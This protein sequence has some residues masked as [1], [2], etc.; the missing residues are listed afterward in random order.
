MNPTG[1][2]RESLTSNPE[3]ENSLV[4]VLNW[5]YTFKKWFRIM[6]RGRHS[7]PLFSMAGT[8]QQRRGQ[9]LP[10]LQAPQQWPVG[11]TEPLRA[12]LDVSYLAPF[13]CRDRHP[14]LAVRDDAAHALWVGCQQRPSSTAS[15]RKQFQNRAV[16]GQADGYG[17]LRKSF[18]ENLGDGFARA[19][20]RAL[21][22]MNRRH[23]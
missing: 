16:F 23:K 17:R 21:L 4:P 15:R 12:R 20:F 2:S 22:G 9:S 8:G 11:Q 14:S 3:L 10:Y 1:A 13:Y 5:R 18:R 19:A 6:P 7:L